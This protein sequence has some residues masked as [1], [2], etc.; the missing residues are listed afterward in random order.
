MKRNIVDKDIGY[1]P[2]EASIKATARIARHGTKLK[3][4][5]NLQKSVIDKLKLGWLP[6]AITGRMKHDNETI[7]VSHETIYNFI[8]SGDQKLHQYLLRG[9]PRRIAPISFVT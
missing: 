3:R 7:R 8:C 1:L 9:R 4:L 6:D 5:L 2:D